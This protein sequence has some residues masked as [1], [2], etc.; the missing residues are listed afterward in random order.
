VFDRIFALPLHE[1]A[2]AAHVYGVGHAMPKLE[3]IEP[4]LHDIAP[5][6]VVTNEG[7]WRSQNS[8]NEERTWS[9]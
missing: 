7:I 1:H 6:A 2:D 3:A 9:R 4:G 5:D 8:S